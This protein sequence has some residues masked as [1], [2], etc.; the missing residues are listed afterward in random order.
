MIKRT[1]FK[2]GW[3][4]H[5][6]VHNK[7]KERLL[8]DDLQK[9]NDF[10]DRMFEECPHDYFQNGSRGS[11]LKF[12][13]PNL[14]IDHTEKHP[15]C[16]LTGQA[17]EI[18]G[19]RFKDNHMKVQRFM[20]EHDQHTVAMEVPVWLM[21][22]EFGSFSGRFDSEYP[23]TGHIDLVRVEDGKIWVWDYKPGAIR[24]KYAA[25]QTYF[26]ALM[27]SKRT[28]IPIDHFMCGW[29]DS[30]NCYTFKPERKELK[31]FR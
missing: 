6:C 21:P 26:Y 8:C 16:Y 25:T 11:K 15:I 4:Y 17:L 13:L 23:L 5:Y 14:N 31:E 22:E 24:E 30:Y 12:I 20:L 3:W 27:L 9:L 19:E 2:H 10:L 1:S 28:G 29:F 18:N 7:K